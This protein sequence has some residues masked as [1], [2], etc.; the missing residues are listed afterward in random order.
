MQDIMDQILL[1]QRY[2]GNNDAVRTILRK[3]RGESEPQRKYRLAQ[4][5]LTASTQKKAKAPESKSLKSPTASTPRAQLVIKIDHS[6]PRAMIEVRHQ[7][8]PAPYSPRPSL[9][10][11]VPP[12]SPSPSSLAEQARSSSRAVSPPPFGPGAHDRHA[13]P[14]SPPRIRSPARARSPA[15]SPRDPSTRESVPSPASPSPSHGSIMSTPRRNVRPPSAH[16]SASMREW[17]HCAKA[18]LPVELPAVDRINSPWRQ[19]VTDEKWTHVW[20][21]QGGMH[22]KLMVGRPAPPGLPTPERPPF[23]VASMPVGVTT[24]NNINPGEPLGKLG[25]VR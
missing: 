9:R 21:A 18:K 20:P 17:Q 4:L 23:A 10:V 24:R 25:W 3:Q 7:N 6:T 5:A 12:Q 22:E 13:I 2:M 14:M 11:S 19:T 15:R 16:K 1:R 8:T